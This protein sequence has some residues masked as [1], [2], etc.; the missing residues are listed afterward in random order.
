M[1]GNKL[2]Y[3]LLLSILAPVVG[4]NKSGLV[5]PKSSPVY[6]AIFDGAATAKPLRL[7]D[8]KLVSVRFFI[9]PNDQ[10]NGLT[11]GKW[12][13]NPEILSQPGK[14]ELTVEMY[15]DLCSKNRFQKDAI[16]FD[17]TAGRST[18]ANFKIEPSKDRTGNGV[19]R[20]VFDVSRRGQEYD[21]IW[22]EVLIGDAQPSAQVQPV[23][24]WDPPSIEN[25]E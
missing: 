17:G 11:Q 6:N 15:C 23:R 5:T 3:I 20:I 12:T 25:R 22:V 10:Q 24:E 2:S 8:G 7:T 1:T 13:V 16:T 21:N 18:E 19:G 9:G 4:C 14:V